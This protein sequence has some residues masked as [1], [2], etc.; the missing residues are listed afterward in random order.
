MKNVRSIAWALVMAALLAA[1]GALRAQERAPA[2]GTKGQTVGVVVEET[3]DY[4]LLRPEG[5]AARRVYRKEAG[6]AAANL[7][8]FK[9][10]DRVEAHW[11][12]NGRPELE[13]AAIAPAPVKAPVKAP[14][15]A[16][17]QA[18]PLGQVDATPGNAVAEPTTTGE[19]VNAMID[20]LVATGNRLLELPLVVLIG[21]VALLGAGLALGM[22]RLFRKS[23]RTNVRAALAVGI[24]VAAG[25]VGLLIIDRKIALLQ[26]EVA[27]LRARNTANVTALIASATT[28]A[29]SKRTS[30]FIDPAAATKLLEPAFGAVTVQPVVYDQATDVYQVHVS[31]TPAQVWLAVVDLTNPDVQIKLQADFDTKTLTSVFAKA[32]DCSVAINGEAGTSPRQGSGLGG[33]RGFMVMD[34]KLLMKELT[35]NPRPYLTF[36]AHNRAHFTAMTAPDRTPPTGVPTAIWGRLDALVHG[37]VQTA[38]ERNRQPRT[39]MAINADGTKLYLMVVDGRQPSYSM[40]F[41]RA[42]VGTF[43]KAFGAEEGMLCDEGGSS[44]MYLEQFGGIAN[45]PSDD[46]GQERITYTHFGISLKKH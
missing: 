7:P 24:P 13:S 35:G 45:V 9:P 32:N 37:V 43:L 20:N 33:W 15:A 10:G 8:P 41:T 5:E 12:Y 19:R 3:S 21:G 42:E 26:Q 36:D 11:I 17:E 28:Q 1:S 29:N 31:R 39:A 38:N 16:T 25:M 40:G 6:G 30:F 27:A 4:L 18:T 2:A 46:N 23:G 14:A 34:G 22:A 44:C